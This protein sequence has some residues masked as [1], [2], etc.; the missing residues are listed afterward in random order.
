MTTMNPFDLLK[1]DTEDPSQLIANEQLK[2]AA[3]AATAVPPKKGAAA[4]PQKGGQQN[5]PAQ[6]PTKP[7]PPGQAVREAK[8]EASRGGR[9]GGR[10]AGRGGGRGRGFNRDFSN[11]EGSFP[12]SGAPATQS[13][14]EEGDGGRT[15][16]RRGGYG[17]RGPYRGG[18]RGDFSNGE[19][20]EEGRPRRLY[21]RRSGTGRGNE[22]KREGAGR[23][24]WGTQS[25]EIAQVTDEVVNEA[26]KNLGEEKPAGEDVADVNKESLAEEAEQ[27]EPEDKEMTLEEYQKVL[28]EKRKALQALKTEERKVDIKEFASMQ[29]LSNKK[30]NNDIFIKLGSDK[31]RRKEALEREERSKKSV[32]I[33]EFL[34]PADGEVYYGG[35]GRGRP[36]GPKGG[37]YRGN[38]NNAQ[39]PSIEDPGHFPTLGGN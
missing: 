5:K 16:D 4:A 13:G 27:K 29:P 38:S 35:R 3:A 20:G 22:F 39:A 7:T 30:V 28:E 1:D 33:N 17:G 11:D 31:D 12:A 19:A 26:E 34:K 15:S 36:R 2:A 6:L 14:F 18:R 32:S 25:D 10:G 9:G 37:S 24:N 21:E 23:G 8:N